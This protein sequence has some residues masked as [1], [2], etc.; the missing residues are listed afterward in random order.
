MASSELIEVW[1][2]ALLELDPPGVSL[3][4]WLVVGQLRTTVSNNSRSTKV[5]LNY[6]VGEVVREGVASGEEAASG[7]DSQ[8]KGMEPPGFG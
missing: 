5:L 2:R 7:G 3:N 4:S 8:L 1:V 6:G